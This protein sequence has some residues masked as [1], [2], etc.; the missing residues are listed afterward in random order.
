MDIEL[1]GYLLPVT[2]LLLEHRGE[3]RTWDTGTRL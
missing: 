1:A 3:Q 2:Q